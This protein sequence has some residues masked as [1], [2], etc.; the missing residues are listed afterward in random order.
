[1]IFGFSAAIFLGIFVGD[2]S[3]VYMSAPI[4]IWLGASASFVPVE[5][6]WTS[7]KAGPRAGFNRRPAAASR[8]APRIGFPAEARNGGGDCPRAGGLAGN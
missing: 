5:T 3:S 2:H 8:P 4:L 7:R 1:V 6:K